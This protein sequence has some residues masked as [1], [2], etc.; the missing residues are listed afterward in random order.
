[1]AAT[2][3][4]GY[5]MLFLVY[6]FTEYWDENECVTVCYTFFIIRYTLIA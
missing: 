6:E 2:R 1:M 5:V 3:S 4:D